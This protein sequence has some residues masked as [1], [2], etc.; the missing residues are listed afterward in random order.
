MN[1]CS[2]SV[3]VTADFVGLYP[4]I[5]HESGL[6]NIK[7]ALENSERKSVPTR[8]ILKILEIVFKE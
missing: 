5:P 6:N 3:L 4:S 2:K 1:D 8:D 7:Q